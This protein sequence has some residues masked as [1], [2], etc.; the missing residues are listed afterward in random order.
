VCGATDAVYSALV[1]KYAGALEDTME[2]LD[3]GSGRVP[4][5]VVVYF[6][7]RNQVYGT[8]ET[9]RDDA[10]QWQNTPLYSVTVPS[11]Y[12]NAAGTA[13][14]WA[15]FTVRYD[16]DGNPVAAD[17]ATAATIAAERATQFFNTFYR[18]TQGIARSV[19]TGLIPFT[20][21]SL[22]DGVRW[23]NT[24]LI[25]PDNDEW[26]GWRTEVIRGY[27]WEDATFPL[28]LQGLTGPS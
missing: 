17:V 2:Y 22:V 19:Y 7:R 15:D 24:G 3:T 9:V 28:T 21:G 13:F 25:D 5:Q 16:M 23:Y 11:P 20:T 10:Q 4:S 1:T 12:P 26:S 14:I 6:H 8:E 27:M 18:G